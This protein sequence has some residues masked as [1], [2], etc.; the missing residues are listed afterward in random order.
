MPALPWAPWWFWP[1]GFLVIFGIDAALVLALVGQ[2]QNLAVAV[3]VPCALT[4][5]ALSVLRA[6]ARYIDRRG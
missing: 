6:L 3:G 5:V 1:L 4:V 2:H